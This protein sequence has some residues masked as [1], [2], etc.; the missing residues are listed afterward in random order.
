MKFLTLA[1]VLAASTL[2]SACSSKDTPKHAKATSYSLMDTNGNGKTDAVDFNSN[3]KADLRFGFE[4]ATPFIDLGDADIIPNGF[5]L[6]CDGHIDMSWCAEPLVDADEDG[7]PEALDFDC[8]GDADVD[9]DLPATCLPELVDPSDDDV[10]EGIDLDCDGDVDADLDICL[11][12]LIDSNN[13]QLP[14]GMDTDCDGEADVSFSCNPLID[15]NDDDVSEG[16]DYDCDGDVDF[17]AQ[18]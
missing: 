3:Q 8:D 4:C 17:D 10:P 7:V 1:S 2:F 16:I 18:P 9:L 12:T 14:E 13:D 15:T 5:D 11:P 6:D